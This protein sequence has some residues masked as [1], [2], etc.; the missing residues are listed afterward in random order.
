MGKKEFDSVVIGGGPAGITAGLYLLRA[1]VSMVL[2]EKFAAGG[3][4][5]NTDKIEN[6]PG[7]PEGIKGYE[8]VD[9]M[10]R[11]LE[12]YGPSRLLDEVVK[13]EI[14]DPVHKVSLSSGE[15]IKAK[16][17]IIC[18][19]ATH[20]K[21][22]IPGEEEFSGRG[23]SYCAVCDGNFFRGQEVACIGGGNTALEESL[24]L[25][26]IVKKVYLVH[27]RDKFRGDKVLQDRV[28]G[29]SNIEVVLNHVPIRIEG[30]KEEGVSSLII[31]EKETGKEKKLEV[32]GVF[33]F[34]GL[35][36]QTSFVPDEIKKDEAGFIITD[37]EM[38][39]NI[40]GI[41]AAGD[42]RSK[43]CRQVVTAVGDG[44]TAA[45]SAYLYL[46]SLK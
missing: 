24:Y 32:N 12:I 15:E 9:R 35:T 11:Q 4:V 38:R 40:S 28:F 7:F 31:K 42:V 3:Q 43:R 1:G 27:R 39:T 14:G 8:L 46:E 6:Y 16:T 33:V 45:H 10:E 25:S 23:V 26:Q 2:I 18:S 44:A 20:R 29:T 30:D 21:L 37:T 19:G 41:F 5:L 34:V 13:I 17:V 22:G 36:P